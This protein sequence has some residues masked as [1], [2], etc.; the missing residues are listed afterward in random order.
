MQKQIQIQMETNKTKTASVSITVCGIVQL[1][2]HLIKAM[3]LF[4]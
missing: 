2:S 4:D 1:Q 3:Y